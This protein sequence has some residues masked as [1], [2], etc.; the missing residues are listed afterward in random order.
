MPISLKVKSQYPL[1]VTIFNAIK[2][3]PILLLEE[4][5]PIVKASPM[6]NR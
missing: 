2:G 3:L 1:K 5:L 6:G 4:R